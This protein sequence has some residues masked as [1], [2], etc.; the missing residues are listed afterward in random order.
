MKRLGE[1]IEKN[2]L[3]RVM[4]QKTNGHGNTV[5]GGII[6]ARI[7]VTRFSQRRHGNPLSL[8]FY[9]KRL[10]SISFLIWTLLQ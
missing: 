5:P 1:R 8:I 2:F 7:K 10:L 6:G 4:Y 9:A 3:I